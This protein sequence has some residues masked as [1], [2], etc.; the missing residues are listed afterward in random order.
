MKDINRELLPNTE[1]ARVPKEKFTQYALD[2]KKDKD[3]ATAFQ[4]ALGY[5]KNNTE[6]AE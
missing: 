5:N 3:K 6:A 4:K 2:F 1:N